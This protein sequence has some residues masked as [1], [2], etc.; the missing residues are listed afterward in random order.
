MK[1][2]KPT[3]AGSSGQL[4]VAEIAAT[5]ATNIPTPPPGSMPP[6][7]KL[8]RATTGPPTINLPSDDA[9]RAAIGEALDAA[10]AVGADDPV[11]QSGD[12]FVIRIKNR[13]T[14]VATGEQSSLMSS[15]ERPSQHSI[16]ERASSPLSSEIGSSTNASSEIERRRAENP[17]E[18]VQLMG[19]STVIARPRSVVPWFLIAALVLAG[20]GAAVLYLFFL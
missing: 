11:M 3:S 5:S 19:T 17:R 16:S 4:K 1:A 20:A 7:V 14:T 12:N 10:G 8:P 15:G 13:G 9:I 18:L 2:I 6:P